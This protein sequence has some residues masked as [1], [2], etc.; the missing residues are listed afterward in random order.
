[1]F[2]RILSLLS[3]SL[4]LLY[5]EPSMAQMKQ[6][7]IQNPGLLNTP[8][9][10]AMMAE[11]GVT[12][13]EVKQKISEISSKK[14][15]NSTTETTIDNQIDTTVEEGES[16]VETEDVKD[17]TVVQKKTVLAK[18]INPFVYQSNDQVRA[19]LNAKQQDTKYGELNRYS[20]SFYANQN[21]LDSSSLPT[22]GDYIMSVG[23]ELS[24]HL[25]GDR[26]QKYSL[27][28]TNNGTV[29]LAFIGPLKI[30]G[31]K[32]DA[33]K[34]FLTRQLKSHYKMSEFTVNID[35]Y[36]TIQTTLIGDVKYPGIYNLS[37]FSTVKDLLIVAKGVRDSASVRKIIVKR[38]SKVIAKL[39]FY[40]LLFKGKTFGSLLLKHG[41]IVIIE[42]AEKLVSID[43]YVNNAAIFE[44]K[45]KETL[46]TLI[47][48][49]GGMK[50]NASKAEIKISRFDN[51][52][53]LV[54][55]KVDYKKSKNFK[56]KDGDKVYIYPLDFSAKNSINIYGNIIRPGTYSLNSKNT[57]NEFFKQALRNGGIKKFFL[58]NTYFEYGVVKHYNDDL[59][60]VSK[61]FNLTDVINGKEIVKLTPNDKIYIFSMSDI[62][63]NSYV[64]TKGSVLINAGKLQY[65]PGMTIRDAVN[66]S[67]ISGVLD[68]K[69]RLTTYTT[70]D[71]MPKTVFYSL[72]EKGSTVLNAY[73]EIEVYDYYSTHILEPVS[74]RG[75]VVKPASIYY[76]KGMSVAELLNIA[77][78]FNKTA[79][80]KSISILRFYV[81]DTQ[82]RQQKILSYDLDKVSLKEIKLEPYDE[83]K[84]SKILGWGTQDY[85]TVTI[86]GEVRT[87]LTVKYGKGITVE[88][89]VIMAGGLTKR[90]Y[91][92]NIEIVRY[93]I[94]ENQTRQRHIVKI[95]T[96]NRDLSSIKLEAYDKVT[97][98]KIP[99]WNDSRV[100][101]IQG[102]VRFPGKYAVETGEKLDSIIR[103]A[104]GF[105]EEAFIEGSVFTRES[106]KKNQISQYNK[107]L[108]RLKRQLA[109]F[110]AM[111]ANA[112]KSAGTGNPSDALN[113]VILESKKYQPIGRISIRLGR[114]LDLLAESQYNLTLKDQDMIIVPTLIDTVTVFG[115]V[116]NPTS[117]IYDDEL[118][119]EDYITMASGFSSGADED[120]V[121][122]IHADG[123]SE[124]II[125]GWWIFSSYADIQKGDTVVVPLY[126]Q[127]YNQLEL[128]EGIS[129]II[130][131]FAITAATL[132]T[133][134]IF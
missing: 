3:L 36:S 8:Q 54:T 100:V 98:F 61:S 117:F 57:L 22:P 28:V 20:I 64:T 102:E 71:Y 130:S 89:I 76:E 110:N 99:K 14:S 84:I 120:S 40:D 6:A 119:A 46:R 50:A 101:E 107:T 68:D 72:K 91:S 2:I 73:D 63:S 87:P 69:V 53:K 83:V 16:E 108:A 27:T 109:L 77:G 65:M 79:Y 81:D 134:G 125:S 131:S 74:I 132:K 49:A 48:Y 15:E 24:I 95:N 122:V 90:A 112:R 93:S 111:P 123:T 43:G 78:G 104:G 86:S 114:D 116:F 35:K 44:L 80:T 126:I 1:M 9:A 41:D 12:L 26:D 7:V 47:D 124:P 25:Y 106:V 58:P 10:K 23:D 70:A 118:G 121:Y 5:A 88:D 66:A 51:N 105:T 13:S 52:S 129:K 62:Y 96:E 31:M 82:T 56:M 45:G 128:W 29:D 19:E 34:K 115:E 21:K 92:R 103:R 75:E 67:G 59:Q 11:K 127:E 39:D 55:F 38:D 97:I 113:E 94:D 37:S 17:D 18:R 30:G 33:A 32:F 85:E 60:Y 133:L 4:G 42:K